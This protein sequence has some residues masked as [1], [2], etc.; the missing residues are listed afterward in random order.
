MGPSTSICTNFLVPS[1]TA[2]VT[3]CS[4]LRAHTELR[5]AY[6]MARSSMF[7][8]AYRRS[9]ATQGS[10]NNRPGLCASVEGLEEKSIMWIFTPEGFFSI[11][12]AD[13]FGEEIMV[14]ARSADDLDRLRAS[15]FP[16]L[17]PNV[18]L[19]GRD[20]PVRAFTSRADLATCLSLI[21][22]S[23]DYSNFKSEVARRH[24]STRAHIYGRIW[25]DCLAIQH[26]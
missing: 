10:A 15:C 1:L 17:G 12:A 18:E 19:P 13:E 25:E 2:M 16:G 24:S 8:V 20:Y 26:A 21:A 14:R 3:F 4:Q 9:A 5:P 11:V 6:I 22:T 7:R 23:L